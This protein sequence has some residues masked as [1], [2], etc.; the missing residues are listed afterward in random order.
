MRALIN[1]KNEARKK[2]LNDVVALGGKI[3]T[4][5]AEGKPTTSE[6]EQFDRMF[7]DAEGMKKEIEKL[8]RQIAAQEAAERELETLNRPAPTVAHRAEAPASERTA[9]GF[10]KRGTATYREVHF[11]AFEAFL[12]NDQNSV[13]VARKILQDGGIGPKEIH[14][15]LGTQG[16]LGGFLIPED[17][18]AVVLKDKPGIAVIRRLARVEPTASDT[19]VFPTIRSN[20][21]SHPTMYSTG[22]QGTWRQQGYVSGGTAPTVQNQPRFGQT[23]I[24]V[25]SWQPD[26]IELTRE[27]LEDSGA[28]VVGIAEQAIAET[29]GLDEDFA[30]LNAD[31][32]GQPLGILQ[33]PGVGAVVSGS[34]SALTYNGL[35]NLFTTLA[36]QYRGAATFLM[37]SL[38]YG[39]L[40]K[41]ADTQ[42]RP[43]FLPGMPIDSLWGR[44]IVTTEFMPEIAASAAAIIFGDFS[45]YIIADREGVRVQRLAERFAPNIGL[46]PTARV[47]GQISRPVAFKKQTIST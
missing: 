25:W 26:A 32:T 1:Q 41:L 31:G 33:D 47:G 39:A 11:Q 9:E 20:A 2:L 13:Q 16:D 14:V 40:L 23:R 4:M 44:P 21:G 30:Y 6:Q 43:L 24:P 18:R 12:R 29:F 3:G 10:L 27:L 38:T 5:T 42:A 22:F 19:L 46:L 17:R 28:N 7:S 45:E 36:G 37:T 8:E 15:L 35:V 34:A